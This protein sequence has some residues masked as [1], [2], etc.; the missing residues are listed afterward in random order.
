M[1]AYKP[2]KTTLLHM[3]MI[4]RGPPLPADHGGWCHA[5]NM[6]V[7]VPCYATFKDVMRREGL[8]LGPFIFLDAFAGGAEAGDID[9]GNWKQAFEE[10]DDWL[11]LADDLIA[12]GPMWMNERVRQAC[13]RVMAVDIGERLPHLLCNLEALGVGL[14]A[15]FERPVSTPAPAIAAGPR[16]RLV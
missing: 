12:N 10:P 9:A 8:A 5:T 4:K 1:P 14:R 6:F 15:Y 3:L 16:L 13:E 7:P 2:K 11:H